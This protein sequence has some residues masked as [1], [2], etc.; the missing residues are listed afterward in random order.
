M[1][2]RGLLGWGQVIAGCI[3]G[4]SSPAFCLF[5]LWFI[6]ACGPEKIQLDMLAGILP[7]SAGV[8]LTPT[9]VTVVIKT[10]K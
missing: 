4:Q 1:L 5:R 8:P 10:H 9:P 2:Q 3:W 6:K 7:K